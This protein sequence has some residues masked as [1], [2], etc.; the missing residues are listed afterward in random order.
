MTLLTRR[1]TRDPLFNV[2]DRFFHEPLM[3][4]GEMPGAIQRLEEGFLPVDVSES[5]T[6][7]IVRAS[8]PGFARE[9]IDAEIH[10]NV[11]TI[12]AEHKEEKEERNERYFRK[13]LRFGSMSRR[14]ALPSQVLDRDIG[15]ELKD[16]VLTL[17]M[18][19]VAEATP[20]KIKIG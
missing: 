8:V 18:P 10:D 13:E 11:L 12:K 7:V 15:A 9:D 6:H 20:R 17:K 2:I 14:V 16:G 5:D 19:K 1:E 3:F 4:T